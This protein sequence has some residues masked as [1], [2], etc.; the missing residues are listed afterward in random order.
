MAKPYNKEE[1][2]KSQIRVMFNHIARRYDFLNHLLSFGIDVRWRKK[3]IA[4]LHSFAPCSLL[5]VATGTADLAI[6]AAK[7]IEGL[8]VTGADLSEEM[9]KIGIE[10]VGKENLQERI[11][12]QVADSEQL[13]FQMES[14]DA[15]TISFGIRN[16]ENVPLG[17]SEIRRVLQP[18]KPLLILE[19]SKPFGIMKPLYWFY[20]KCILPL[21]GRIVSKDSKA[22]TYLPESIA[23]FPAGKDFVAIMQTA[24]FINC[25][26]KPLTSGIATIYWGIKPSE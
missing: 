14:F 2:K 21:I 26:Y 16:F 5:D 20:T 15:V 10:K 11:D 1:G 3:Q 12:L 25:K 8:K 17:L 22:Y 13:P 18:G 7:S 19:F 6:M 4:I 24:G 23:E 9:V